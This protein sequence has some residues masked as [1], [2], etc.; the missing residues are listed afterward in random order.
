MHHQ[1]CRRPIS[2]SATMCA[3]AL[4]ALLA[5]GWVVI[6]EPSR[7]ITADGV[8]YLGLARTLN[9]DHRF[10]SHYHPGEPE[11]YRTPIYP[12]MLA[13]LHAWRSPAN[14]RL[15][16]ILQMAMG[17]AT[18]IGIGHAA[19][20][21][22]SRIPWGIGVL[23][24]T[25]P[26]VLALT[27]SIGTEPLY[28]LV[29]VAA[30]WLLVLGIR[31]PS[32]PTLAFSGIAAG[33]ATLVRPIG[34]VP[35]LE[36][37]LILVCVMRRP[38]YRKQVIVW[39]LAACLAPAAWSVR[40]GIEGGFWEISKTL[41]S[42][43]SSVHGSQY[44]E[45]GIAPMKTSTYD[46]RGLASGLADAGG[47]I[48]RHPLRVARTLGVGMARTLLGPGE[49]TLRRILLGESG[50]RDASTVA[51]T[52]RIEAGETGLQFPR[53]TMP[54]AARD[55]DSACWLLL[56]WSVVSLAAIYA[57]GAIGAFRAWRRRDGLCAIW[58]VSA[59]LL[60]LASAGF[61]SNSRFRMPVLPFILLLGAGQ[62]PPAK[63]L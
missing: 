56:A 57:L 58:L 2:G 7:A 26:V 25:N 23:Y 18:A 37:L 30:A 63:L 29:T 45:D 51:S 44:L 52:Y 21:Q 14:L 15:A 60:A 49:W 11:L 8:E 4:I 31:R 17:L 46:T 19:R 53:F 43:L 5:V 62:R 40:N 3:L 9:V 1:I 48:A 50:Y 24:L 47:A 28:V 35:C 20:G 59:L 36:G 42:F 27:M 16:M 22:G 10:L 32:T 13:G 54:S 38:I 41:P 6:R 34:I 61:D 55:R 33:I 12:L 39:S